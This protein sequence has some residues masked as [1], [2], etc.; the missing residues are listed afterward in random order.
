MANLLKRAIAGSIAYMSLLSPTNSAAQNQEGMVSKY[1]D[2]SWHY[3]GDFPSDSP[4]EYGAVHI[5]VFLKLSYLQGFAG[6]LGLTEWPED[7]EKVISG[8]WTG[9]EYVMNALDGKLTTEDLNE[10][11]NSFAQAYY[12]SNIFIEDFSEKSGIEIYFEPETSVDM[13]AM[14]R[15]FEIRLNNFRKTGNPIKGAN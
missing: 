12:S 13:I 9:T 1:D 5:G 7:V 14:S 11:G 8:E 15:I 4:I 2:A 3:E 6:E 10:E